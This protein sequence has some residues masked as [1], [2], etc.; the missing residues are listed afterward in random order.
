MQSCI[1]YCDY[2]LINGMYTKRSVVS[3]RLQHE[4]FRSICNIMMR[5][6]ERTSACLK[7][8]AII[9]LHDEHMVI[10][11]AEAWA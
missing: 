9:M 5:R 10:I 4:P 3:P 8:R 1:L 11:A 6:R 2:V 7:L